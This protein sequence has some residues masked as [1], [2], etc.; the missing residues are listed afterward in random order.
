MN[1]DRVTMTREAWQALERK[2]R[3]ARD[4]HAPLR[5]TRRTRDRL[6]TYRCECGAVTWRPDVGEKQPD[7]EACDLPTCPGTPH[8]F[9]RFVL[10]EPGPVAPV[11]H[12]C[13]GKE[14]P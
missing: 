5:R 14:A 8:Y 13:P 2:E 6:G 3:C 7:P 9:Q 1:A 10:G 11:S 4:G 12:L